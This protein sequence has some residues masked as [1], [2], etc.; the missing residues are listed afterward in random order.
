MIA[1]VGGASGGGSSMGG[2]PQRGEEI[3][4]D[5]TDA[6]LDR[7]WPLRLALPLLVMFEEIFGLVELLERRAFEARHQ[8]QA[9]GGGAVP[10]KESVWTRVRSRLMELVWMGGLDG[11]DFTGVI[12]QASSDGIVFSAMLLFLQEYETPCLAVGIF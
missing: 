10:G 4:R 8:A 11:A 7:P 12:R 5:I 6:L 3:L 2:L 1:S 9:S